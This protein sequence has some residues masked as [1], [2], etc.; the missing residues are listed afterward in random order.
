V[1][2][3]NSNHQ[4][5]PFYSELLLT[6]LTTFITS[7]SSSLRNFMVTLALL[8]IVMAVWN[9]PTLIDD[10]NEYGLMAIA[11][12]S[13]STP[14]IRAADLSKAQQLLPQF[15]AALSAIEQGMRAHHEVPN[16]S[17]FYRGRNGSY[18]AIHFFA[19]SALAAVPFKVLQA[20][21]LPPF[22]CFQIVNLTFV[23]ILGLSL[24]RLFGS[25]LKALL[26]AGLFM[27]CGGM[28]YW[29]LSTPECMCA[30]ALLAGL[31]LFCSGAPLLGCVLAGLAATQNPSI[32][33]FFAFA[34]LLH[35]CQH[36][37][38][39]KGWRVNLAN[40]LQPPALLGLVAGA[41][42]A[43]LPVLFNLYQFSVPSIIA[44]ISTNPE[45]F[46]LIRLHSFFF[47][48]NQG[49][50]IGIPG[51]LAAL[52]LWGWCSQLTRQGAAVI[53]SAATFTLAMALPALIVQNWNSG[54]IGMMRYVFWS[55]MPIVYALLYQLSQSARW[56]TTLMLIVVLIQTTSMVSARSYFFW[57]FSPMAV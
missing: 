20:A 16:N 49:M 34:S 30:A 18:F 5:H 6:F 52:V 23:F 19:Y 39:G 56:P 17:G 43:V 27:L 37:Q 2:N 45:L 42:L 44:K 11:L 3:S 24:Y 55:A 29:N 22:K 14:D 38:A 53:V 8:L 25:S 1:A 7:K 48:L 9:R 57:E 51:V 36:Y 21:G 40:S 33:F 46:S 32:V 28:L 31:I 50:I 35:L 12:A 54:A 41:T 47:D 15:S 13:H 10:N 26:G 4:F